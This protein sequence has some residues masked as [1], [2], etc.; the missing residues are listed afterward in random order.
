MS[1]EEKKEKKRQ[2]QLLE[3]FI[4]EAVDEA[5]KDKILY[6]QQNYSGDMLYKAFAEPFTDIFKTAQHSAEKI[7][8]TASSEAGT[9][10]KQLAFLLI[11]FIKPD[12]GS[13]KNMAAQDRQKMAS[14]LGQIDG[15]FK[16]VIDR[17]W[18]AFNNPDV[19]GTLFLMHPQL[20]IA[21]KLSVKAPEVALE[22]LSTLTGGNES[23]ERILNSYRQMRTG[24]GA[25][26]PSTPY[27]ADYSQ[28]QGYS[29]WGQEGG[30]GDYGG[31]DEQQ[32]PQAAPQPARAQQPTIQQTPVQQASQPAAQPQQ[33]QQQPKQPGNVKTWAQQQV[34]KLL[35][36]PTV[37]KQMATSKIAKAMQAEAVR[38]IINAAKKDLNLNFGQIKAKAGGDF[39][40][41]LGELEKKLGPETTKNIETNPE[42]QKKVVDEVKALLKPA[43]I[44]Q[45]E[46]LLEVNPAARPAVIKGIQQIQAI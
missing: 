20:A 8:A 31:I 16:D 17:N 5:L 10:A 36:D 33:A 15:K 46:A 34:L 39:A 37:K 3:V 27:Q 4:E 22:L 23:V 28:Y 19:W 41:M 25:G 7:F 29:Q 1:S 12:A 24:G 40:R 38:Y 32:Q 35:K 30:G 13:L 26:G 2:R 6:E 18:K 44:K 42:M 11:P 43:Y 14:R 9:L 21:Q 45:L